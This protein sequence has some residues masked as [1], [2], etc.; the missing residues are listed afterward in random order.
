MKT[1]I[2]GLTKNILTIDSESFEHSDYN[3]LF[4]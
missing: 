3:E 2:K 4:H 1:K